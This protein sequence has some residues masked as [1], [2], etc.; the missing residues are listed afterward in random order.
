M[1]QPPALRR[2]ARARCRTAGFTLIEVMIVVAIVAILSAIALPAYRN[3]VIR[4]QIPQATAALSTQQ[5][6]M[7]QWYQDNQTYANG[8]ACGVAAPSA[9]K[10]FS[11][12]CTNASAT[13]YLLTATGVASMTG[14]SYTID[15]AGAKTSAVTGVSGWTGPTPNNCWVVNTGGTC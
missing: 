13:A 4:G 3:Y 15:Q 2:A 5:V 1:K 14:F 9:T 11:F 10:Y 8:T 7:E 6:K 12:T